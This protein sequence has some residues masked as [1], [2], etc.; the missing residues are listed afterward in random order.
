[1]SQCCLPPPAPP[2]RIT[3][4]SLR[5]RM[6]FAF[7]K[8]IISATDQ[9]AKSRSSVVQSQVSSSPAPTYRT[10]CLAQKLFPVTYENRTAYR[11]LRHCQIASCEFKGFKGLFNHCGGFEKVHVSMTHGSL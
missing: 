6:L 2:Y 9:S 3:A 1:M 4:T 8:C 7:I 10:S 5:P 11:S